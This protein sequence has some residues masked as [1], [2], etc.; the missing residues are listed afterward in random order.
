MTYREV[1]A[2]ADKKRKRWH[3]DTVTKARLQALVNGQFSL[4]AGEQAELIRG[5][6]LYMASR[7]DPTNGEAK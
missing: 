4:F 6:C 7:R 2:D 5:Y 1:A 3:A